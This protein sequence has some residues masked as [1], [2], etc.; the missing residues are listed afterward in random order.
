MLSPPSNSI[1]K[2]HLA[3][4]E[5]VSRYPK[6]IKAWRKK[7]YY[8]LYWLL[9][10]QLLESEIISR[11]VKSILKEEITCEFRSIVIL[12]LLLSK[13]KFHISDILKFLKNPFLGR[14]LAQEFNVLINKTND[15][16]DLSHWQHQLKET[17]IRT[18]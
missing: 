6:N 16:I 15:L 10:T 4:K 9:F 12:R 3:R 14:N 11:Q 8:S 17:Y 5:Q 18:L 13:S 1:P 7:I 2:E